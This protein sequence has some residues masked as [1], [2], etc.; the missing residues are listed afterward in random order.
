MV[1]YVSIIAT[2]ASIPSF[3]IPTAPPTP[4]CASASTPKEP[5]RKSLTHIFRS[6]PF[7]IVALAFAVYTAA[8]NAFSS[9]LNQ[10][11]YP[12]GYSE[13]EAGICGAVLIIVGLVAAA[14]SSPVFDRTHGYLMGIKVLCVCAGASY[15]GMIWAPQ[16][17]GLAAPYVLAAVLGASSFS[18][19]PVALEYLVEIT[20]PASPEVSSTI[21]WSGGQFLG[22]IFIVIM[23]ALKDGR[24]V[25]LEKVRKAGRGQGGGAKPP[26]N[27]SNALIFQAV[28]A[29]AVL[30]FVMGLGVKKLGLQHGKGRLIVDEHRNGSRGEVEREGEEGL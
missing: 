12:Y 15:L 24:Y 14:I 6:R 21:I 9:L 1:L 5:L 29:L 25:D 22:A 20:Y 30:P 17:R 28:T 3:F 23:T 13:D 11:L 18:L 26:G 16:T 8:F 4:P 7:Y 10:I 19:L 27:M 2:L